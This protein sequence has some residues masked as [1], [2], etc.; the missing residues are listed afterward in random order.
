MYDNNL[1]TINVSI[2]SISPIVINGKS[3]KR[4]HVPYYLLTEE[5]PYSYNSIIIEKIGDIQYMFNYY[6]SAS[7]A[8]DGNY[9]AGLR[10][11]QD[12]EL[13]FYSTGIADS[14]DY[15]YIYMEKYSRS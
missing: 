11:Y 10:C 7:V 5:Y 9:S 2:D 3:L 6:P 8:C 13:G 14:C 1:D 4:L 15:I 12:S